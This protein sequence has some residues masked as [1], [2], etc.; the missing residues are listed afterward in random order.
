MYIIKDIRICMSLLNYS[1]PLP[2]G[3]IKII[4]I[5]KERDRCLASDELG[6]FEI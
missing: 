5:L 6:S 2:A 4:I 3:Y 1:S